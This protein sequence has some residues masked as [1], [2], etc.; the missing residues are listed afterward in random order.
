M[1]GRSTAL[2]VLAFVLV[3]G[4]ARAE[5]T[6]AGVPARGG[7]VVVDHAALAAYVADT[8]APALHRVD[9]LSFEVATTPLPCPAEQALVVDDAHIAVSLRGCDEVA[10][11]AIDAAGEGRVVATAKVPVEPWGLARTPGGDVLVTSAWGHALTA[12]DG[13]T[14]A[15]RFTLDLAKEPRGVAV[16]RAGRRAFVAHLTGGVVTVVDLAPDAAE[17]PRA[18]TVAAV[19][20]AYENALDEALGAGTLHPTPTLG[21]AVT[22]DA[23]GTR[24]FVPHLLA[25]TGA[26]GEHRVSTGYGAVSVEEDTTVASVAVLSAEDARVL[27]APAPH[28]H[29]RGR[30]AIP[31]NPRL[32]F[33]VAPSG[34]RARQARAAAALGDALYVASLGTDE[35]VELDARAIDPALAPRRTFAVG[36]G[37][38]GVDV[39]ATLG[40]AVVWNQISRDLSVVSLGSGAVDTIEGFGGREGDEDL[41]A[42]RRLFFTERDRR[43]SRDGRACAACHPD[44]REDGLVWKLGGG[45]R[46]TPMLAGRVERGPFGWLAEHAT[47]EDHVRDTIARLGG[48]GLPARELGALVAFLRRG[49]APPRAT[50]TGAAAAQRGK[51]LFTSSELGCANCHRPDQGYSDRDLHD[52][53]SR[54]NVDVSTK[55]RTPSLRF[56][57][58]TAP[59]FHDGRYATLEALVKDNLDRMGNTTQLS[60]ADAAALVAYLRTL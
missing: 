45:P 51:E 50:E 38:T 20:G 17:G 6:D 53:A 41:T 21:Y 46:Q 5:A 33:A 36:A 34:S 2:A 56:V 42:G 18:R 14:L 30:A 28:E 29:R 52:V 35:L 57:A 59:Y 37:P 40:V 23:R 13:A 1:L 31:P 49:L 43:I 3:A 60:D 26:E 58:G 19:S 12:L 16:S 7:A 54:A 9:L 47:L 32:D 48:S 24:V 22:L 15:R 25:Q 27:G 39:D 10:L 4:H 11:V 55:F 44:G 8:D